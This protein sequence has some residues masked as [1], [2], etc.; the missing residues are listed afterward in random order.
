LLSGEIPSSESSFDW[1]NVLHSG[2]IDFAKLMAIAV[3]AH[4]V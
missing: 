3:E 1:Q 2:T 4:N